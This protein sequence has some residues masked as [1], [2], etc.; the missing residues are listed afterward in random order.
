MGMEQNVFNDRKRREKGGGVEE[1]RKG[2]QTGMFALV[3]EGKMEAT[4]EKGL[5]VHLQ[6]G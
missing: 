2:P 3:K 1:E 4:V 5:S 6:P